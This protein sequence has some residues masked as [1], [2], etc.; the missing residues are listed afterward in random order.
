[1]KKIVSVAVLTL[2]AL[3]VL[4]AP[5]G[6]PAKGRGGRV[7]NSMAAQMA[8][9]QPEDIQQERAGVASK[10]Q[11]SAVATMTP[12]SAVAQKSSAKVDA[13]VND[14]ISADLAVN[15]EQMVAANKK[16]MREK[17]KMACQA[18]NIGVGNTF[19]WASR[20]SNLNS[21]STMVEDI[22][23]PENNTCFV[24]VGLKSN[25]SKIGVSDVPEKYFEW[26]QT[27]ACGSWADYDVLKK[28]ILDAKKSVHTWATVAGAVGGAAVGVG[29]M[30]GFGNNLIGGEVQGQKA[31]EGEKLWRSQ[32]AVLKKDNENEYKRFVN[33]LKT[34][35]TECNKEH[36]VSSD[37]KDIKSM[38]EEFKNL[39]DDLAV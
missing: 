6:A 26:G 32:L 3:P 5:Y 14:N 15:P 22:E 17:E 21:Y 19:V 35:K 37:D 24:K 33:H 2:F 1:M 25:D 18:N 16:D 13:N 30:E 31:L 23:S 11:I 38:C 7:G 39:F 36:V 34:L 29:V 4:A 20:Y 27:I 8:V 12:D 10:N 28:R 9:Q